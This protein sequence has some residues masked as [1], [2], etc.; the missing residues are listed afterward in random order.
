M[1]D[2]GQ[3]DAGGVGLL[4]AVGADQVGPHLPGDEHGGHRVEHRVGDRGDEVGGPGA[5]RGE[6]DAHAA[7]RLGVALGRMS[8]P[9]LVAA[10]DV[11]QAAVVE[12]VVGRQVGT[13]REAEYRVDALGLE[14]LDDGIDS[15]HVTCSF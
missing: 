6:G 1:L 10:E 8:R 9:R 13:P 14:A 2:H 12:G 11:A 7:A 3:G 5:A 15:S 4:E